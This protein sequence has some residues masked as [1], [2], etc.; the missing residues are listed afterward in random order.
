MAVRHWKNKFVGAPGIRLML[1]S[2]S[3]AAL[4]MMDK[5]AAVGTAAE[6]NPGGGSEGGAHPGGAQHLRGQLRINPSRGFGS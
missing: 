1:R 2:D 6:R 3:V 5:L 4:A